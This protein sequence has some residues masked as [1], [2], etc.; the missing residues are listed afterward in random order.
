MAVEV[1]KSVRIISS[2]DRFGC[3]NSTHCDYVTDDG[4]DEDDEDMF[5][6]LE[7]IEMS[8]FKSMMI[9]QDIIYDSLL[10]I[11]FFDKTRTC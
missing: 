6:K 5:D 10:N 7:C 8:R 11:Y 1:L 9:S 2:D 4:M 3:Y